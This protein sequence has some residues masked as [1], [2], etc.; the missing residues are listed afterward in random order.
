ME[1]SWTSRTEER[2]VRRMRFEIVA[3]CIRGKRKSRGVSEA[4]LASAR[5]GSNNRRMLP[6]RLCDDNDNN[7]GRSVGEWTSPRRSQ[8]RYMSLV[9]E[10]VGSM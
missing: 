6:L 1:K 3:V 10:A 5:C 7:P 9:Q 8:L 4:P 2:R